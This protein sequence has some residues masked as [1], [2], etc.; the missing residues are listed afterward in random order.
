MEEEKFLGPSVAGISMKMSM[1]EEKG[2]EKCQS[3]KFTNLLVS[4]TICKIYSAT[5]TPVMLA[6]WQNQ[7]KSGK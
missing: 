5:K 2:F 1:G 4:R 6:M 7:A 3:E